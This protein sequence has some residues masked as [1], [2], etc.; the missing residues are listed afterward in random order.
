MDDDV[1]LHEHFDRD[2]LVSVCTGL[3]TNSIDASGRQFYVKNDDCIGKRLQAGPPAGSAP[4]QCACADFVPAADC[5]KDLQRILHK[6][7]PVQRPAFLALGGFNLAK[8][9]LVPL[10]VT[11]PGDVDVVYNARTP[12]PWLNALATWSTCWS[13]AAAVD[14]AVKVVTFLTMPL[15]KE[16]D[17]QGLQ[18]GQACCTIL[19]TLH[20]HH[21]CLV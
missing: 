15:E 18:V 21:P 13:N 20:D 14:A 6:D 2:L 8:T 4:Q 11:F 9:D 5:L 3:G 7:D 19:L 1:Q 17:N 10:M 16:S 12:L